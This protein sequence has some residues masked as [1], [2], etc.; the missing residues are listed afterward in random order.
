MPFA[1]P[2]WIHNKSNAFKVQFRQEKSNHEN[3]RVAAR[4]PKAHSYPLTAIKFYRLAQPHYIE[5][6]MSKGH[7]NEEIDTDRLFNSLWLAYDSTR[8]RG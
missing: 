8:S 2:F 1:H 3:D 4:L 6:T 7:P 5:F